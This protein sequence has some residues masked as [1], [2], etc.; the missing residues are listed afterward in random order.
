MCVPALMGTRSEGEFVVVPRRWQSATKM[1]ELETTTVYYFSWFLSLIGLGWWLG[2]VPV[3]LGLARVSHLPVFSSGGGLGWLGPRSLHPRVWGF[4]PPPRGQLELLNIRVVWGGWGFY[5]VAAF[6]WRKG[7]TWQ[8]SGRPDPKLAQHGLCPF[9]WSRWTTRP[10]SRGGWR[11]GTSGWKGIDPSHL[12]RWPAAT[13][14]RAVKAI[15]SGCGDY[16]FIYIFCMLSL[17][18][19]SCWISTLSSKIR[20]PPNPHHTRL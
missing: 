20:K 6:P 3:L 10:E 15:F 7:R 12:W 5:V 1:Q 17:S 14:T 19:Y 18:N 9:H 13:D 8:I 4:R 11:V 2:W 16:Q